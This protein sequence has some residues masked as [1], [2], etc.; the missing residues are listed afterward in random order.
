VPPGAIHNEIWG[1]II[2]LRR[3]DAARLGYDNV[4][5]WQ[6]LLQSKRNVFAANMKISP[7]NF[8]W[9]AAFH[10]ESHHPHVHIIAYSTDPNEAYLTKTGIRQ[11]KSSLVNSIFSNEMAFI[12][13]EQTMQRDALRSGAAKEVAKIA[14]RIN[15]NGYYNPQIEMLMLELADR[16]KNQNGKMQYGY[17][18]KDD[19]ILIDEIVDELAKEPNIEKLYDLWYEKRSELFR[20]YH[21]TAPDRPPLSMQDDFKTIKNAVIREALKINNPEMSFEGE[22]TADEQENIYVATH[23]ENTNSRRPDLSTGV[24]R[25][26]YCLSRIMEEKHLAD[27]MGKFSMIDKKLRQQI[28]QKK[29]DQGL[30]F[31]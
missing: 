17:L 20:M 28:A 23:T 30:K 14:E 8:R 29:L 5:A 25:L 1:H 18:K 11:I 6:T 15:T 10:N 13:S 2:S 21:S 3:E 7:A 31:S 22:I 12:K 16:L 4:A 9:Y 26:F 24:L 19:K 27:E